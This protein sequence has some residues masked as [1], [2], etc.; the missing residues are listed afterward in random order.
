MEILIILFLLFIN[1]LFA[2]A[3]IAFVSSRKSSLHEMAK[4]GVKGAVIAI[5]QLRE[6][7]KFLST[8]QVGISLVGVVAGAYGGIEFAWKI[9]PFFEQFS[10]SQKYA[11]EI[12]FTVI[13]AAIT[14][15][16]LVV[17][18]LLPKTIALNN[19]E[20]ITVYLAP[21]MKL[22][23]IIATPIIYFLSLSTRTLITLLRVKPNSAPPVSEQELK[24]LIEQGR[25]YGVLEK[26]E[27]EIMH[28][29]FKLTDRSARQVMTP[30]HNIVWL[31]LNQD[32]TEIARILLDNGF[33]KYPVCD[34]SLDKLIGILNVRDYLNKY[35][36]GA[37]IDLKNTL[38]QPI[39]VPENAPALTILEKF[40]ETKTYIAV[41][42]DEYGSTEGLVTLHDLVE[43]IF[44]ELPDITD[45]DSPGFAIRQDGSLLIDGS[46]RIDDLSGALNPNPFLEIK[47][48][49]FN[50]LGGFVMFRL[51][52]IPK[53]GEVFTFSGYRIE[54]ADMDGKRVDKL[55][56]S[57]MN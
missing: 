56:V 15:L 1:G 6:P 45:V 34:G 19:P 29:V 16:S 4:R 57:K 5:E 49:D 46:M 21:L 41:I 30:R 28:S 26:K 20:R 27:S 2:M 50:T 48:D 51:K 12:A 35:L 10:F 55:I 40:K 22:L 14:Y 42:V 3:E 33:T 17:G 52:K 38:V 18:E 13:V 44:G 31:D 47:Q 43:T 24:S 37:A 54:V 9:T 32:K 53:A 25:Q 7:E 36:S 23:A 39:Y 11:F 8:V